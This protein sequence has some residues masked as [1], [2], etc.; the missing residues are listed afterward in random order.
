MSL[1][2]RSCYQIR[3]WGTS[4]RLLPIF[5]TSK[6]F[7]MV[8]RLE[9]GNTQYA[10]GG[11][12][13]RYLMPINIHIRWNAVLEMKYDQVALTTLT[14]EDRTHM[15]IKQKCCTYVEYVLDARLF[16]FVKLGSDGVDGVERRGGTEVGRDPRWAS[17]AVFK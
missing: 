11:K 2:M 3:P 5:C 7:R 1:I 17:R 14:D 6:A 10:A 15:D 16:G 12:T 8:R 9:S 13:A 4:E